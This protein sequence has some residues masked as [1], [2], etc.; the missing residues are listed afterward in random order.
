MNDKS[1]DCPITPEEAR[2]ILVTLNGIA[3]RLKKSEQYLFE[4]DQRLRKIE[5]YLFAGRVILGFIAATAVILAWV[6]DNSG[7]I[8]SGFAAWLKT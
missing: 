4:A 5:R 6:A 7:S 3:G 8:K 2:E 1:Q